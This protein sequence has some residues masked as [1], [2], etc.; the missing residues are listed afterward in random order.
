MS[1]VAVVGLASNTVSILVHWSPPSLPSL[2]P[3]VGLYCW[4]PPL[5]PSLVSLLAPLLVSVVG[6]YGLRR[7][8]LLLVTAA[9]LYRWSL[10][11]LSVLIFVVGLPLFAAVVPLP[12]GRSHRCSLVLL[13]VVWSR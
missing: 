4:L 7:L 10:P 12:M 6:A 13:S 8:S 2:F 1:V 3:V 11:L 9:G 5:A